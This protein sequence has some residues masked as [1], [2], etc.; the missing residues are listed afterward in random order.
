MD[1]ETVRRLPTPRAPTEGEACLVFV[2]GHA[3]ILGQR[4]T[5]QSEVV[6]GR[7]PACAVRLDAEDVSR[8]HARVAPEG[9][10]HVVGDLGSLN[11]TWV[12]GLQVEVRRLTSGDRIRVGP[13][14]AKYLA[15]GDA[16]ATYHAELHRRATTDALTG[17]RNRANFEGWLRREV[18]AARTGG[19]P[20]AMLLADVDHF[21]RVNDERGHPAGD[22]V[23]GEVARRI[24]G[25]VRGEDLVARVGGEEFAVLL[26]GADLAAASEVA[27]RVRVLVSA[28]PVE[29][30]GAT[31]TV[32]V[33]VGVS[34]LA[35]GDDELSFVSRA[36]VRLYEAKRDGRDRVRA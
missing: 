18:E 31:L 22:R 17:L 2:E 28:T 26:P 20:L 14:V 29:L 27:E 15:A 5:L 10:G 1:K 9:A 25:A 11:G 34:A 8:R 30:P 19:R 13:Y 24:Q 23:L 35:E 6:L 3:T 32:T 21:K 16:E 7:D 12:N 4:I 33:S 36:D